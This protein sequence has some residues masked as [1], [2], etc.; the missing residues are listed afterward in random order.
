MCGRY[1]IYTPAE[2]LAQR[3]HTALPVATLQPTYNAA[4]SQALPVIRSNQAQ[5]ITLGTWGFV[6]EWAKVKN[7]KAVINARAESIADKPFFRQAFR[8]KRCLVLADGFYE[9]KKVGTRKV[10]HYISLRSGEPFA[11]AGLWSSL[12]DDDSNELVTYAIITTGAND[13]MHQVHNRMPVLLKAADEQRWLDAALPH[14]G[15]L[16][17]LVPYAASAMAMH[18]VSTRVNTPTYNVPE[19]IA[20]VSP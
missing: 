12:Q 20:A 13:L 7:V 1:T 18:P 3:F 19:A 2:T 9:W 15:A 4:P 8:H 5:A 16:A 14:A 10:P 11:F 6:P 17:L